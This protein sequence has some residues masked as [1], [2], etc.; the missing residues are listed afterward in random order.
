MTD[1]KLPNLCRYTGYK[2]PRF[3]MSSHCLKRFPAGPLITLKTGCIPQ[4]TG[5]IRNNPSQPCSN[6]SD[7]H[8]IVYLGAG[9]TILSENYL[10]KMVK[11][12]L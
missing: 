7:S 11:T 3:L 5:S 1:D 2:L 8:C 12:T 6:V 9:T 10:V 4:Y